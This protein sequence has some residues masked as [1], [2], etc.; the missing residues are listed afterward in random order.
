M[1]VKVFSKL[2]QADQQ[3]LKKGVIEVEGKAMNR[4]ALGIVT[5]VF[6]LYPNI[7][8]NELK[9]MLPDKINP[10]APK[11][12]KHGYIPYTNL[13]YGV[14]QKKALVSK[15]CNENK[16]ADGNINQTHFTEPNEMFRTSDGV[17]VCVSKIWESKD[18]TTGESDI[19]NLID[20]V[21]QY[22]IKVISFESKKPFQKGGFALNVIDPALLEQI[23]KP[24]SNLQ[25]LLIIGAISLILLAV[26]AYFLLS[27]KKETLTNNH[28]HSI[29]E[30]TQKGKLQESDALPVMLDTYSGPIE[31][32]V[33]F[34][35]N[36]IFFD[37]DEYSLKDESKAELDKLIQF[38]LDNEQVRG[39]ISGHTDN[40]G[41]AQANV[42]L[43]LKRAKSVY[44]YLQNN[45]IAANRLV[46]KGYGQSQ[47][48]VP[49][50]SEENR[51]RNRRI[52]FK[53]L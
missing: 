7:T 38:M 5:A 16:S 35:L 2:S 40:V 44:E 53:I 28:K 51:H 46:F 27:K 42:E 25:K 23:Q 36:N 48:A 24:A 39:E 14:V 11:T 15:L 8:Y 18:T 45:G 33:T 29:E 12:F 30:K 34:T 3:K 17:T 10:S 26:L 21:S 6:K 20:H 47:P 9:E 52:E 43:S 37:T 32:G 1:A 4:T 49:N 50:D 19:Q 22:G 31:K 13:P 41:D